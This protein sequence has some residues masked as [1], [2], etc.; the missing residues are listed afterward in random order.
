MQYWTGVGI[1]GVVERLFP[2]FDGQV[3]QDFYDIHGE[4]EST[5]EDQRD[6]AADMDNGIA[7]P[8]ANDGMDDWYP[9]TDNGEFATYR[10]EL[11]LNDLGAS[12]LVVA[13]YL[14]EK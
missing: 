6:R 13:D 8:G 5:W 7:E 11:T 1:E 10:V 2:W 14:D 3:D 4:L 9:Y 12:Y